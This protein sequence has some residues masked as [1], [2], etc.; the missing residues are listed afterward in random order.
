MSSAGRCRGYYYYWILWACSSID[1][2][3]SSL[4][5]I[6]V[7][8]YSSPQLSTCSSPFACTLCTMETETV[9][10]FIFHWKIPSWK[11]I[12]LCAQCSYSSFYFPSVWLNFL[13]LELISTLTGSQGSARWV[14]WITPTLLCHGCSEAQTLGR[15]LCLLCF[16]YH[17]RTHCLPSTGWRAMAGMPHSWSSSQVD[18]GFLVRDFWSYSCQSFDLPLVSGFQISLLTVGKLNYLSVPFSHPFSAIFFLASLGKFR[19]S[20]RNNV[21]LKQE[22]SGPRQSNVLMIFIRDGTLF[23]FL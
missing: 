1:H 5:I 8:I 4:T 7:G 16:S 10:Y 13:V 20:F 14:Y 15:I 19:H 9:R 21:L 3:I 18:F 12:C 23:Y 2:T 6:G 11:A 17:C 22:T